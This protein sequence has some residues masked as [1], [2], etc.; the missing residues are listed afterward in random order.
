MAETFDERLGKRRAVVLVISRAYVRKRPLCNAGH[1][2][3]LFLMSSTKTPL[4]EKEIKG[5]AGS[6]GD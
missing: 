3:S 5:S 6:E 1:A 2:R 4:N